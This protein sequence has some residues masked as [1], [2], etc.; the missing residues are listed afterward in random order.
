[1]KV[2]VMEGLIKDKLRVCEPARKALLETGTKEIKEDTS[3]EFWGRGREGKGQNMLG[4]L[5]MQFREKLHK[6]PTFPGKQARTESGN[7]NWTPRQPSRRKWATRQQQPTCYQCGE[8][9]HRELQCRQRQTVSCWTC[10]LAGHK[11]KHC[12]N[13]AARTRNS[14]WHAY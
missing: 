10:G 2:K 14:H 6:D 5:W 9:G 4:K 1:M 12:E 3:H 13:L 11:C 8:T 7:R